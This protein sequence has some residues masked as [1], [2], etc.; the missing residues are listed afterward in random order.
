MEEI[1]NNKNIEPLLLTNNTSEENL[2]EN[3]NFI[4]NSL[5][6]F[7]TNTFEKYN[8]L[9]DNNEKKNFY[10]NHIQTIFEVKKK[11]KN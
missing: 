7:L 8:I 3:K 6:N 5:N 1:I 9:F 2:K 4:K 10:L 11:L